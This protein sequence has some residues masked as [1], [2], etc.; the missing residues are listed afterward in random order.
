MKVVRGA[1]WLLLAV[2][3]GVA[4]WIGWDTVA[5]ELEANEP[6]TTVALET[7]TTAARLGPD[8]GAPTLGGS[9]P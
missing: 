4:G 9:V 7:T 1:P 6:G 3:V 8:R 2:A 5:A